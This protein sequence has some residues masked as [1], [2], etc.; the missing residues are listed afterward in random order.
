MLNQRLFLSVLILSW[1]SPIESCTEMG[2]VAENLVHYQLI[3]L[4]TLFPYQLESDHSESLLHFLWL[5]F[6]RS[7]GSQRKLMA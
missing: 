5:P 6:W 4:W 7:F 3:I 2:D 1:S